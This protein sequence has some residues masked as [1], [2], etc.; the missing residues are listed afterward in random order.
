MFVIYNYFVC[1]PLIILNS[2]G[3][4]I[5]LNEQNKYTLFISSVKQMGVQR[6]LL[7]L[8]NRYLLLLIKY[9]LYFYS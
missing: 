1:F 3:N 7:I 8:L 5:L 6:M 4:I 9:Q 2:L